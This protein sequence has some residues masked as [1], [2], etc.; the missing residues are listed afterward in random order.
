MVPEIEFDSNGVCNFC[1]DFTNKKKEHN[2][3]ELIKKFYNAKRKNAE[4]DC[5]VPLSGGRDSSY[6]LYLAKD[7]YDLNVLA[8]NYNNEFQ[9]EQAKKN[10]ENVVKALNVELIIVNSKNN[11]AHKIVK[12]NM[13]SSCVH[14]QFGVCRACTY[15]YRSVVYREAINRKIPLILWGDS[16][17]EKTTDVTY[18]INK[19]VN[20]KD[21]KNKLFN[22]NYYLYEFYFLLQR[23]EFPVDGN[24]FFER[25]SPR[26]HD[27]DI[28]EIHIFDYIT[29]N[30]NTIKD[31]IFN[32][33]DWQKP[34]GV[35]SSWRIDCKLTPL[36]NYC[37]LKMYGCTKAC[38][39]YHKMINYGQMQRQEALKNELYFIKNLNKEVIRSI[40]IEDIGIERGKTED[41]IQ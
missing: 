21:K 16:E 39:G 38:F 24:Y 14:E 5:V 29:W 7:V 23:L 17:H 31:V 25:C 11:I 9:T 2:E 28:E 40:V 33:L 32:K 3:K 27:K 13:L 8:V 4:Y 37:F 18:R 30:R 12:H 19:I 1:N 26:L 41:I 10:I 22:L 36:I 20:N 35:I 6:V 34:D 15:G